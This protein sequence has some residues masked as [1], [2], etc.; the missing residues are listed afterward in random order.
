[1]WG[2]DSGL[3]GHVVVLFDACK[4]LGSFKKWVK[5]LRCWV[6]LKEY[7]RG[8]ISRALEVSGRIIKVVMRFGG[9]TG[10]CGGVIVISVPHFLFPILSS[11]SF[12][13]YLFL[14]LLFLSLTVFFLC[15]I[16]PVSLL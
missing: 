15:F 4:C 2:A 13:S 8:G 14:I 3:E 16:F 1:M 9:S 10:A 5:F 12:F 6:R 7:V 11:S